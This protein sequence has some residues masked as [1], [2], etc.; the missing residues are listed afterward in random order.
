MRGV[1]FVSVHDISKG[2][3]TG[4]PVVVRGYY[5]LLLFRYIMHGNK[6]YTPHKSSERQKHLQPRSTTA[7]A[8]EQQ[9]PAQTSILRA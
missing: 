2:D 1:C 3:S 4:V 5:C 6:A 7:H 9:P 8:A